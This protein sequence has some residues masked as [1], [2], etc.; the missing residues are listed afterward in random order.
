MSARSFALLTTLALLCG[1]A[2]A[3]HSNT[4][5][6]NANP[7]TLT[8]TVRAFQWHNPHTYIQLQVTNAQGATEEWA[9]EMAAPMY[10]YNLGWRPST[11]KEGDKVTV[12]MWPLRSGEKGGLAQEVLDG[13]G[14]HIGRAP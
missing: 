3:H 1:S 6:D 5:F 8:G 9:V 14:E 11:L 13:K 12:A 7:V 10:L 2:A 4:M